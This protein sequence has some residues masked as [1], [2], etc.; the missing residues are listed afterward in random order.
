MQFRDAYN[1]NKIYK[2]YCRT[3]EFFGIFQ[4]RNQFIEIGTKVPNNAI[5]YKYAM[6]CMHYLIISLLSV[7]YESLFRMVAW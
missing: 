2:K 1:D 3:I 6:K 7:E 5:S 4:F